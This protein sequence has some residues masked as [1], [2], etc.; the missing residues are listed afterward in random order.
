MLESADKKPAT[1][2]L[3]GG[4]G[5]DAGDEVVSESSLSMGISFCLCKGREKYPSPASIGSGS[6]G[7]NLDNM[8]KR[9]L[10]ECSRLSL[11][12]VFEGVIHSRGSVREGK[13]A[14]NSESNVMISAL[15]RIKTRL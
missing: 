1:E 8:P 12:G 5:M 6:G 9:S 11:R 10:I 13:R 15:C 3:S 14:R 4:S 7:E 2:T